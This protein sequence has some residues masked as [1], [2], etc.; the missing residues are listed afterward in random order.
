MKKSYLF[1]QTY[2]SPLFVSTQKTNSQTKLKNENL[3]DW[4]STM[5]LK[6]PQNRFVFELVRLWALTQLDQAQLVHS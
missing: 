4:K 2:F 3:C 1:I 5:N 6:E